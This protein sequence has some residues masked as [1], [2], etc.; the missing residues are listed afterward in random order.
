MC[1]ALTDAL[2]CALLQLDLSSNQLCGLNWKGEGTYTA[3]GIKALTDAVSVSA[4]LTSLNL[5]S[6]NLGDGET[7]YV[8]VNTVQGSSFNEGDRVIYQGREM[9]VSMGKDSDGDIKMKPVAPD[10]SGVKALADA[11]REGGLKF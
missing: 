8:K 11:A 9:I 4:S 6:N 7:E 3:E 5:S 2:C 10:L 1:H